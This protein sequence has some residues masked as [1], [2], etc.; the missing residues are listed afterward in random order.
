MIRWIESACPA[1]ERHHTLLVFDAF[2]G[3]LKP[4]IYD[5]EAPA[6]Q[7][8]TCIVIPGGCTSKVQPL[9]VSMNK[10][11]KAY[12]RVVLEEYL[13]VATRSG[14]CNIPTAHN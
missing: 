9:D 8:F 7:H 6:V 10:P 14:T 13:I 4:D 5:H 2:S 1:L 11:F 12:L 3:H